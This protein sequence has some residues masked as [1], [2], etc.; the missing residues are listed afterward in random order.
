[1]KFELSKSS[2]WDA[3]AEQ[4]IEINTLEELLQ[5]IVDYKHRIIVDV[6]LD[7]NKIEIYDDYRE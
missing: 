1:M 5:L 6:Q 4:I 3:P 7:G 2:E